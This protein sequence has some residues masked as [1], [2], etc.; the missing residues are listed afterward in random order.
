MSHTLSMTYLTSK[1][2]QVD[3]DSLE[4]DV[5]VDVKASEKFYVHFSKYLRLDHY[6]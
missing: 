3:V 4:V 5:G 2:H 6:L 1:P